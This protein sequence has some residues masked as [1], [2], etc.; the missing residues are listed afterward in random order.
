M[1]QVLCED[2]VRLKVDEWGG[3]VGYDD[4]FV[5]VNNVSFVLLLVYGELV[6]VFEVLFEWEGEDWLCFYIEVKWLV[7]LLKLEC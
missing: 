7:K 1:M 3:Y 2:Y 5:C 6:L 4:W